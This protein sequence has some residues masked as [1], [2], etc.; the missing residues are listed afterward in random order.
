MALPPFPFISIQT[1]D[2][3]KGKD[4]DRASAAILDAKAT[5]PMLNFQNTTQCTCTMSWAP[6]S[7]KI[8]KRTRKVTM[9]LLL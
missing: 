8:K 1:T 3:G 5:F 4:G 9:R 6:L 7:E 2:R